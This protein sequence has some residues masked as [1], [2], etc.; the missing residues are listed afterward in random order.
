MTKT[1]FNPVA[2]R[3]ENLIK[4]LE[5][6]YNRRYPNGDH[7]KFSIKAGRKYFKIIHD[8]RSVHAFIDRV[9][10]DVFKPASWRGPADIVRYNL[11]DEASYA[12]CCSNA[13]WA[14]G[15]LYIR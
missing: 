4:C 5:A 11:L 10:G 3:A 8:D 12:S 2:E 7:A 14:G 13:D 6:D 15:Y 9:T 1:L